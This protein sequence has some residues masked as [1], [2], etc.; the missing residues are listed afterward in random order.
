MYSGR[1]THALHEGSESAEDKVTVI[2]GTGVVV[3]AFSCLGSRRTMVGGGSILKVLLVYGDQ[4][5]E[6]NI[7]KGA[8]GEPET[9]ERQR[10]CKL[11]ALMKENN[12]KDSTVPVGFAGPPHYSR[13]AETVRT[14]I[15]RLNTDFG[16]GRPKPPHDNSSPIKTA[17]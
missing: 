5:G 2:A 14:P 12:D 13:H 7:F 3:S 16:L 1:L 9:T 10:D 8:G 6:E 11:K 17:A 4:R 15:P